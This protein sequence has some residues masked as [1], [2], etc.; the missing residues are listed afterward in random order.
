MLRARQALH[1]P[2]KRRRRIARQI[3]PRLIELEYAKRLI[4]ITDL[5]KPAFAPFLA[6]LPGLMATHARER[7]PRTDAGETKT[8]RLLVEQA[9][10]NMDRA[11]DRSGIN[12]LAREFAQRTSTANRI[13]LGDQ[14]SSAL[15]S[16]IYMSDARIAPIIDGFVDTNAALVTNIGQE[17]ASKIERETLQAF[18]DGTLHTDLAA[19]LE[20]VLGFSEDRAKLVARDQIGKLYGQVN[21]TRQREV[22][23]TRFTWRTVG[24][25]RVREEHEDRDGEVYSYDDPPDGELPGEPIQ[26]RCTADPV[27][28]DILDGTDES[29]ESDPG[30]DDLPADDSA[31]G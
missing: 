18:Q 26:C 16:N 6:Q 21:A 22:G 14:L 31:E 10:Q 13:Q 29:E 5:I 11:F 15:G 17:T 20:D 2:S 25:E 19:R 28:D 27:F 9:R 12:K 4:A 8:T 30:S 1:L 3:Y 7:A 23:I 24:D